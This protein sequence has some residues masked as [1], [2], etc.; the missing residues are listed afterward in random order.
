MQ[1]RLLLKNVLK[2]LYIFLDNQGIK[3]AKDNAVD[4]AEIAENQLRDANLR[5]DKAKEETLTLTKKFS[6]IKHDLETSQEEL[7]NTN[8]KLELKEKTL[9]AVMLSSLYS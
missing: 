2:K 7:I 3:I 1:V 4:R 8:V 6:Q 5:V 9:H